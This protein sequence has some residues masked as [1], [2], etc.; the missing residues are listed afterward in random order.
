LIVLGGGSGGLQCSKV[1]AEYGAK[2]AVLDFVKPSTQGTSWG[3]GGTCVNVGCIPKKLMHTAAIIGETIEDSV[4]YGWTV[5]E[6]KE[7]FEGRIGKAPKMNWST[8]VDNVQQ[9]IKGLNWGYKQ[10]LKSN[11]VTYINALGSFVDAHTIQATFK[12]GKTQLITTKYVVIAVGGRPKVDNIPGMKEYC[13]TSDD[14]FSMKKAPGKTLVV[15]ASYVAL[16][17]AGF[18]NGIGFE[19]HVMV[20]SIV[21]RGFDRQCA[22]LIRENMEM[23]GVV[24]IQSTIPT[25]VEKLENGRLKVTYRHAEKEE[26][27][28]DEYDTVLYAIGRYPDTHGLN[29]DAIG[30]KKAISGKLIVNDVEQTSVPNVFAIGDVIEGG[31]E[32]TPVAIHAG[33]LLAMRLFNNSKAKMDYVNVPTTVFTPLEYGC[34]GMSEEEAIKKFG[35]ENLEIYYKQFYVLE[36]KLTHK[37][38]ERMGMVK[39][40]C[41][42]LDNERVV[43]FHFLGPHAGEVTQ[44]VAVAIRLRATKQDFDETI[45]IH[46]TSAETFTILK[47]GVTMDTGC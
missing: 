27:G 5:L 10:D 31:L 2:V 14:I 46:P 16:E 19:T 4:D 21:L 44:G 36:Y 47:K 3:L 23:H 12:D 11:K 30:V 34:C 32:L 20:R 28:S 39:L 29:L 41:N 15:G 7:D 17:C 38:S 22:E 8:L 42:K 25:K 9:H 33:K 1:A 6:N 26:Y 45:G 37:E 24:F 18:L 35:K 43:G 13:I 40:I